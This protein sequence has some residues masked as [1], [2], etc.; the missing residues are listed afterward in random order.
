[1]FDQNNIYKGMN[2]A[3]KQPSERA[4]RAAKRAA[5]RKAQE[6]AWQAK[7]EVHFRYLQTKY[8]FRVVQVD[9]SHW[10][11]TRL[12][13]QNETTAIY[14]DRSVEF[15]RVE[16]SLLR[17][18]NGKI[19]DLTVFVTPDVTLSEF[20]FDNLLQVR[21]PLLLPDLRTLKGLQEEQI[22]ASLAFLANALEQYAA[23]VLRG[24]FTIFAELEELVKQ[25]ARNHSQQVTVWVPSDASE[26]HERQVAE[27]V[28]QGTPNIPVV[29]RKYQ[30]P[31]STKRKRA[32][33][34]D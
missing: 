25:R 33:I 21:A 7:V 9:D 30:H 1:V 27:E 24:D 20:L 8:H 2:M 10:W 15:D 28:Q 17:L 13:Y 11:H 3:N 18:I 32:S 34:P 22:E 4:L 23:D 16:L 14:V 5:A 31:A 19:P 29:V 6:D 26:E 12:V